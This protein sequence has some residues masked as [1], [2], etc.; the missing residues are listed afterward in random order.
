M[1]VNMIDGSK[2]DGDVIVYGLM[3]MEKIEIKIQLHVRYVL[4][5]THI[6]HSELIQLHSITY[7]SIVDMAVKVVV[8]VVANVIVVTKEVTMVN[9][10]DGSDGDGDVIV[11]GSM[12]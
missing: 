7:V 5:G 12:Q 4:I 6:K 11:C 9:E 1:A 10:S 3:T 8:F 2:Y